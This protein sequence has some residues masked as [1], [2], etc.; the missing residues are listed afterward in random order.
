MFETRED[1]RQTSTNDKKGKKVWKG[2]CEEKGKNIGTKREMLGIR[3]R[4]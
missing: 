4:K 3:N 2:R 1:E